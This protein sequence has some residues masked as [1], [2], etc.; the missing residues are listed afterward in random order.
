[1]S[2]EFFGPSDDLSGSSNELSGPSDDLVGSSEELPGSSNELFGPS[3]DLSGSSSELS[4]PSDDLVG[5]SDELLGSR[6]I[7]NEWPLFRSELGKKSRSWT[8]WGLDILAMAAK[9]S[10]PLRFCIDSEPRVAFFDNRRTGV[11]PAGAGRSLSPCFAD[12]SPLKAAQSPARGLSAAGAT[13][14]GL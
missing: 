11:G 1:M 4:G 14:P 5:S 12:T 10:P 7:L 3:D 2:R 9:N 8:F 6:V 13:P